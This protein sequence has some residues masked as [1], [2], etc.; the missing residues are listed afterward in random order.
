MIYVYK[1]T[2]LINKRYYIGIHKTDNVNDGYMGSG[3][4]IIKAIKKYGIDNFKKEILFEFEL[5]EDAIEKEKELI[6]LTDPLIYNTHPGGDGGWEY[7]NSLGLPNPMKNPELVEKMKRSRKITYE[8]NKDFYN[9]IFSKNLLKA[10]E[11]RKG[12]KDSTETIEKRRNAVRKFYETNNSIL[13]NIPKTE[14]E[15]LAMSEGWTEEKRRK[16]SEQQKKRIEDN[17][18]VVI[19]NLGKKFS[20]ETKSKMSKSR[21]KVWEEKSKLKSTCPHCGKTGTAINMKRWHFE[22]CKRKI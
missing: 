2:N 12:S 4:N 19:T 22:R 16:K 1:I 21:K 10:T 14:A 13:K 20:E 9:E 3:K 5:R 8:N 11:K 15:K 7:V 17:P 18:S 6:D